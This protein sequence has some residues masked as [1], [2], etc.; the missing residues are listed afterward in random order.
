[1]NNNR[2]TAT[3]SVMVLA[4]VVLHTVT[5]QDNTSLPLNRRAP[6]QSTT[7]PKP[8]VNASTPTMTAPVPVSAPVSDTLLSE[9][10]IYPS[11]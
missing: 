7:A 6:A 3:L 4:G 11:F 8:A 9:M 1:M 10:K 5:P 2:I